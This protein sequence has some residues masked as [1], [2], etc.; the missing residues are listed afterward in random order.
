[1]VEKKKYEYK[2]FKNNQLWF[3]N[4]MKNKSKSP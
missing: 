4:V 2:M 1:M 3:K